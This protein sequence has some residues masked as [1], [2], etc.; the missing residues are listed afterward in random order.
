VIINNKTIYKS[1]IF[2]S[3]I[4]IGVFVL[5]PIYWLF[6]ISIKNPIELLEVPPT[7]IPKQLYLENYVTI[8]GD[9]FG[10]GK[11]FGVTIAPGAGQSIVV[12]LLNS[13]IVAISATL[14]CL[15]FSSLAAY[16]FS[17][18]NFRY[19]NALFLVYMITRMLPG[20]ILVIPLFLMA[21]VFGLSNNRFVLAV[22]YVAITLPFAILLLK[23]YFDQIPYDLE[24]AAL[25][26]GCS[27]IG[28]LRKIL[29]PL[30]MP[31]LVATSIIVFMMTWGEFFLALI[32]MSDETKLTI[33]IV[34][35]R[36]A[37]ETS[38]ID[39]GLISA[40]GIIAI[41]PPVILAL[42]FQRYI[43][44]GLLSGGIKG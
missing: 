26:D 33:P 43:I 42:I 14:I 8:C 36:F 34:V 27:K 10:A 25:I 13:T 4:L 22:I 41:F 12:A 21:R 24:E 32:L 16:A 38:T 23:N 1:I 35:A 37:L 9:I 7:W 15:I 39:K 31:G 5:G 20:L 11:I 3:C 6:L 29:L 19:K 30:A 28:A 17:R 2:I 18:F 40:S 44:Q